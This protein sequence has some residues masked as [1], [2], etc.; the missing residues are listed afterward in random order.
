MHKK[1]NSAILIFVSYCPLLVFTLNFCSGHN[2]K[3]IK[4]TIMNLQKLIEHIAKK[5]NPQ[6]LLTV[7]PLFFELLP[8]DIFHIKFL[9]W[10]ELPNH[11]SYQLETLYID[12]T[13]C[14]EVQ[15]TRTVTLPPLVFV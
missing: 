11:K 2:F 3:T 10:P 6:K 4:V 13:D 1:H 9:F 5:S 7:P 15:Y 14:V 12:R 8:F